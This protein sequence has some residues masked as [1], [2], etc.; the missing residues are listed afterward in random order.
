V[1]I[2]NALQV[3]KVMKLTEANGDKDFNKKKP[4]IVSEKAF[5]KL[6]PVQTQLMNIGSLI[7]P[8]SKE[9]YYYPEITK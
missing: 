1:H 6:F 5:N 3:L 4:L 7:D 8:Y 9:I 2:A